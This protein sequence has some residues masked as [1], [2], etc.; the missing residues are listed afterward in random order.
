VGKLRISP[1]LLRKGST[2]LALYGLGNLR[3]ERLCRLFATPGCVE[4]CVR[5][6]SHAVHRQQRTHCS[7]LLKSASAALSSCQVGGN[8]PACCLPLA[9]C[10]ARPAPTPQ[11]GKDDWFNVFV[12]HQNRVAHTQVAGWGLGV[13]CRR[14]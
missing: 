9:P 2:H 11:L 7:M 14:L 6:G 4:W 3:D 8:Q 12:L 13:A 1:V 5:G 10:R